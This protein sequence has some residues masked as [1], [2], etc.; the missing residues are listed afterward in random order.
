[1]GRE[2]P[3]PEGRAEEKPQRKLW[4][5]RF[6]KVISVNQRVSGSSPEGRAEKKAA[7]KVAAFS[8]QESDQC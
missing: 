3:S 8:F 1:M 5:F 7:A 2:V 6:M 4:L